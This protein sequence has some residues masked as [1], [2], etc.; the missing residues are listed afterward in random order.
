MSKWQPE[1]ER[2]KTDLPFKQAPYSAR[3]WGN[4]NH[5]LCSFYGKLK[6][7]IAYF[8]V[9]TFTSPGDRLLDPFSGSGTIPFE[10][11]LN[12]RETFSLD[13]NPISI[14]LTNAKVRPVSLDGIQ[15]EFD[16]LKAFAAKYKLQPAVLEK[17]SAFGFNKTLDTYYHERTFRELLAARQ[18]FKETAKDSA[19]QYFLASCLLHILHGNRPYALSRTSHPITPYAPAGEF[20]YKNVFNKL[21]EKADRAFKEAQR[22]PVTEGKVFETDILDPWPEAVQ[23]LDAIITSPPFFDSTRYYMTNWLRSWFM[24]WETDD[25]DR[26]KLRF[27]DTKQKKTFEVYDTILK[28]A[29]E[30]LKPGSPL[31]FHL[32]KSHKKDMAEAIKPYAEKYFGHIEI[33]NE[34]VSLL[35]KHGVMDKGSVNIHQYML[36][37]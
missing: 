6:P 3:N 33:F 14:V 32:G 5:S 1:W 27:I 20:I 19:E 22:A 21:Y 17:A 15:A 35:E 30:R 29:K 18:Y 4:G 16:R 37:Y 34:D 12:G 7:A 25:F 2:F 10:G 26:E 9:D 13:I 8:L 31:V 28:S 24:G 36:M 23:E 11:A